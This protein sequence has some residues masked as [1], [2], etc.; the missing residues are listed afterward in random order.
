MLRILM[1][2]SF[3][4]AFSAPSTA[5]AQDPSNSIESQTGRIAVETFAEGLEHPWGAAYLPDGT[6]LITERPGRLRL[7]STDGA[8]SDPIDGV[9]DVLAD[10]QGGLLDVALDPDFANN[11]TVYLSYSE[12]RSG[13]AATS[14]G[15]GRLDENGSALSSFEVIFR[16][17]PAVSSRHHFGSRLVFAPDGK[18]FVTLGERGKMQ[19][20]QDASNHLGTVVR[21]N[22]DGSVPDD[23]PFV[24][25]DGAD[26]IWSYGHRNVQSAAI[27]P[28]TG[29]VWTAEMG[30]LGGDELNI[31][32]AGRNYGWPVVSWGRHYSGERIP[33]PSTR[34]EFAGSIHSWT[35]V[36]SPSG[37]TFYTGDMFADWRGDLLIGGLSAGGI[38][39]VRLDSKQ[40][41]GEEVL[42]LGR[43]IRDVVQ[44]P[45]G[46]VM[47]LTDEPAGRILRLSPAA[48]Q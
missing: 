32:E 24:G 42:A 22:P 33:D 39:R 20:A 8:V 1:A 21:I 30:P 29:V 3:L 23:N 27:H 11:R 13:G 45:D 16:Q 37:M 41:A 19:Q 17:E 5:L 4:L 14:V 44:A 31:P 25:K 38:V 26:E 35:P 9:P 40:F 48:S 47:A 18:L 6:L 2:S 34:P 28:E 10:G 36:I 12:Q 46:A 7:V 15:R 43:R